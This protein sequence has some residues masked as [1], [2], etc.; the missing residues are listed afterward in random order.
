MAILAY[1]VC[2]PTV[3]EGFVEKLSPLLSPSKWQLS[4]GNYDLLEKVVCFIVPTAMVDELDIP[5]KL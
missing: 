2:Q 4:L 5:V 3:A 1:P